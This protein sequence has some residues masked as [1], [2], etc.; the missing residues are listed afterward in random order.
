MGIFLKSPIASAVFLSIE[1]GSF[2]HN[3]DRG[4]CEKKI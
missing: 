2:V 1:I 4:G 3:P